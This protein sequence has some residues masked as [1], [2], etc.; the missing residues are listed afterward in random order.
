MQKILKN[1]I[2]L[3][4]LNRKNQKGYVP[5]WFLRQ[6]GRY[7]PEYRSIRSKYTDFFDMI[8][9][10]EVCCELTLQPLRK[11]PLDAAITF[12]D[13]LTVPE[14]LGSK[15]Q[16][17][18]GKG[19]VF[20]DSFSKSPDMKLKFNSDDQLSYVY[21][22]TKLIKSKVDVPLIGFCGSPWTI[23]TYM[24]Y[25]KSPK[26]FNQIQDYV[27]NN[28]EST[29][30]KLNIITEITVE[31]LRNQAQSGA[32]CLQIFDSWGGIVENDY[33]E[34]S[35]QYIDKIINSLH[36][37]IPVILYARGLKI[38]P[39]TKETSA[40]IFNLNVNDDI[41]EYIDEGIAI[42]GNLDPNIFHEN[43]NYLES[44]AEEIFEKYSQKYNYVCNLGS[45]L[46]PDISPDKVSVFLNKLRFLN[47]K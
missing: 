33:Q 45:G 24:Y 8:K 9:K 43:N 22:A 13:I 15:I 10:P 21:E 23:F 31:Y 47:S 25:G 12:S 3:D 20:S 6:A 29:H 39:F 46:T 16:F 2:F 38:K 41:E 35:L 7:M 37:S 5:V 44:L 36:E 40:K 28:S 4:A 30:E 26:N 42:Q 17:I 32:D 27:K 34:F 19:P 11:F 1:R 14:A 18:S